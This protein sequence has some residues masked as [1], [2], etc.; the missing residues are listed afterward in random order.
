M[1][2]C[3]ALLLIFLVVTGCYIALYNLERE[4]R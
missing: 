1:I 4:E 2:W 3:L